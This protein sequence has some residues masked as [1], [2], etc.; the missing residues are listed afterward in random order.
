MMQQ[1][2]EVIDVSAIVNN[3]LLSIPNLLAALVI[4]VAG[5][6]VVRLTRPQL[7]KALR[8]GDFSPGLIELL[9]DSVY[10]AAMLVVAMLMAAGQM[11]VNVTAALAGMGILGLAVGL[12]AQD[13][14]SNSIA[15]FLIFWDKPFRVGD[16]VTV[17]D[18]YGTVTEITLRTTRIRTRNNTYVII[19]NKE[20]IDNVLVNH[21]MYG[22][23]RVDVAIGIAYKESIDEAR[24]VL[25][26]AVADIDGVLDDPEPRVVV[27]GLGDS[28]V[29]LEVRVWV[30]TADVER[31]VT[32]R[33]IEACKKALDAADIEI[34]FPHMQ[35]YVDNIKREIFERASEIIE[36]QETP[37]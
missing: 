28:S 10:T 16:F 21:S 3:V 4:L 24:E 1:F 32:F 7:R 30:A 2:R 27:K 19:P 25:L 6:V 11:G 20:I 31:A 33:T 22:E 14:L 37:Q 17:E 35:L 9:V 13:S 34:P 26:A 36:L 5:Y 15:G 18:E 23:T 12:A 29:D 8:R